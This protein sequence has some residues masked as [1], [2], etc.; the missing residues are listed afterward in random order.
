M[1]TIRKRGTQ[2]HKGP[3]LFLLSIGGIV[4]FG[5]C[6]FFFSFSWL[7]GD[8]YVD[9][10]GGDVT[11]YILVGGFIGSIVASFVTCPDEGLDSLL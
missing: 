4:G 9:L 7:G 1:A 5:M 6:L 10:L 8:N 3:N 2:A 11:L